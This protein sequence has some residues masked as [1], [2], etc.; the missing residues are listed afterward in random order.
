MEEKVTITSLQD[1]LKMILMQTL[2]L[3]IAT[4]TFLWVELPIISALMTVLLIM[5]MCS[6]TLISVMLRELGVTF[7]SV[8]VRMPEK[9]SDS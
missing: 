4:Y 8:T 7:T 5:V 9:L 3:G 2:E 6:R 1:S